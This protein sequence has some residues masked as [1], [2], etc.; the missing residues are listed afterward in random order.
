MDGLNLS[1]G[2][3]GQSD[4]SKVFKN[5]YLLLAATL[6]FSAI[7]AWCSM[8]FR[9]PAP[10]FLVMLIAFYGLLFLIHKTKDSVMGIVLTF[11]LTG[12]LGLCLGPMLNNVLGMS[13]GATIVAQALLMTAATFVGL[14][15]YVART[16]KDMSFLSGFI[17]AGFFILIAAMI[18]AF[19]VKTTVLSLVISAGFVLFSCMTIL[20]QTSQIINGGE[21]NYIVATVTLFIS[22]YN[23]FVSLL[24]LTSFFSKDD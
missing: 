24:S 19:F 14:S 16:G 3:S 7:I 22:I 23:L 9:L 18:A 4:V 17:T 15:L 12:M 5:T 2:L 10:G 21:R 8:A 11:A 6:V 13:N 20:Y 1:S